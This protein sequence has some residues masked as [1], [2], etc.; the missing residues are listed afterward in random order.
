VVVEWRKEIPEDSSLLYGKVKHGRQRIAY[1]YAH[2]PSRDVRRYYS[3]SQTHRRR[4]GL[5]RLRVINKK[6]VYLP[7]VVQVTDQRGGLPKE[8]E[9]QTTGGTVS[10]KEI[11]RAERQRPPGPKG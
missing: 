4:R 2:S 1:K 8:R 5:Q 10:R 3:R 6:G 7:S 11:L 9:G